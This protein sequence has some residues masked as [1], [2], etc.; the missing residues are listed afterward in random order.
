VGIQGVSGKQ[1]SAQQ[2]SLFSG[3]QSGAN[4]A[5]G[6]SSESQGSGNVQLEAQISTMK[7]SMETQ[8]QTTMSLINSSMGVGQNVDTVA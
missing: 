2:Q 3:Q 6:S 8:E 5:S 4:A 7:S 1:F